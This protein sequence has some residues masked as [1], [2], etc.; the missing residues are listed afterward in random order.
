M[1]GILTARSAMTRT[2]LNFLPTSFQT[3]LSFARRFWIWL[4]SFWASFSQ[5]MRLISGMFPLGFLML[6]EVDWSVRVLL[7]VEG[8]L[9][10]VGVHPGVQG[11][12]DHFS[13]DA[14]EDLEEGNGDGSNTGLLQLVCDEGDVN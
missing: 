3:I 4:V 7:R 13:G 1:S 5:Q 10:K 8:L 11:L 14:M 6:E 9:G 2:P 12:G